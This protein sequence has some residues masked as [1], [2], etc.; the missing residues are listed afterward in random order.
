MPGHAQVR[1]IIKCSDNYLRGPLV[2]IISFSQAVSPKR[3]LNQRRKK[4]PEFH[5]FLLRIFLPLEFED[6]SSATKDKTKGKKR[7]KKTEI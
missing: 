4:I 6:N 3:Q 5:F 2:S 7:Q 1:R